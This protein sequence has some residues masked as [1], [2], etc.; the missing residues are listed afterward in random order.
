MLM[1]TQEIEQPLTDFLKKASKVIKIDH[2]VVYGS[3][4]EGN[5]T[6]ESD[7]D[8]FVISDDFEHMALEK[9][10]DLLDIIADGI[11][12]VVHPWGHTTDEFKNASRLTNLGYARDH[13]IRF[14]Q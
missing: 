3:Y 5:A 9:R 2:L 13:G 1:N 4:L 6:K 8:V 10:L 11:E 14:L 7:I 12:P